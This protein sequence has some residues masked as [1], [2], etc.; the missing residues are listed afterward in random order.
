M[1]ISQKRIKILGAGVSGLTAAI[2]L[3]QKGIAV[4]IYEK[5][6][7]VGNPYGYHISAVKTGKISLADEMAQYGIEIKPSNKITKVLKIS[8]FSSKETVGEIYHIFERGNSSK[9]LENQ[10]YTLADK[11]NVK[12]H[13]NIK[14]IPDELDIIATGCP[15]NKKNILGTGNIYNSEGSNLNG[16][17]VILIY[18]NKIIP[19]GYISVIPTNSRFLVLAVSFSDLNIKSMQNRLDSALKRIEILN[20]LIKRSALMRKVTGWG[21]YNGNPIDNC[22]DN[23]ILYTGESAGFQDARRGFGIRYAMLSG[24]FAAKSI[25]NAK[26]YK[27]YLN[28]FF[29]NEFENTFKYRIAVSESNNKNEKIRGG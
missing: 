15:V 6:D 12:F 29:G 1:S 27:T 26:D 23:G 8:A 10:L 18:D 4:D 16:N 28:N 9:S 11:L 17:R 13:F 24:I 5:N 14:T 22:E 2:Y 7:S 21:F 20:N 3:A 19:S 25:V